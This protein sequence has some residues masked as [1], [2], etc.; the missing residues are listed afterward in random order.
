MS[1]IFEELKPQKSSIVKYQLTIHAEQWT[2]TF[3]LKQGDTYIG[4]SIDNTISLDSAAIRNRHLRLKLHGD[5]I[6]I[7]SIHDSKVLYRS[8][9]LDQLT[10]VDCDQEFTFGD[11]SGIISKITNK[12]LSRAISLEIDSSKVQVDPKDKPFTLSDLKSLFLS[13]PK[14]EALVQSL[15]HCFSPLHIQLKKKF[16]HDIELVAEYGRPPSGVSV[17][18]YH[19]VQINVVDFTLCLDTLLPHQQYE[20]SKLDFLDTVLFL[21]HLSSDTPVKTKTFDSDNFKWDKLVG[22]QQR[23][24]LVSKTAL[25]ANSDAVLILGE[26]GTGKE[27]VAQSLHDLWSTNRKGAYIALNCAAIPTELLEAEL[28]GTVEG[29]AT[30]VGS[31]DGRI[32]QAQGG[33]LFL[34]EIAELPLSMQSKLLRVLQERDYYKVGGTILETADIK[35]VAATNKTQTEL[36]SGKVMRTDLFFRLSQAILELLPLMSRQSDLSSLV[37]YFLTELETKYNRGV[38]GVSLS[39]LDTLKKYTW[40]GNIRELQNILR[41]LYFSTQSNSL[42]QSIQLP[43]YINS[44]NQAVSHTLASQVEHFERNIIISNLEQFESMKEVASNLGLSEG[45]LYRKLKKLNIQKSKKS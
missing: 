15:L 39:C 5:E 44:Q 4:S 30:G 29:T 12:D 2:Q 17:K 6:F 38:L 43:G 16:S 18:D 31:R 27:L 7:E 45:Y 37:K 8:V 22:N 40:P 33:T 28:F 9:L 10:A 25:V 14:E 34:D 35:V 23:K 32:K 41:Q 26:T 20:Q 13:L 1:L 21:Y 3:L 24:Q 36:L 11:L 42:I 19:Q